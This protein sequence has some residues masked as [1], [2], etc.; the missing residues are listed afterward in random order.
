M[1]DKPEVNEE[2]ETLKGDI[3][4]LR[5]ENERLTKALI[6]NEFVI[7]EKSIEKK[8]KP[9]MIEVEGEM[10]N[11]ADIPAVILKKLEA[12]AEEL[13][14]AAA[15]EADIELTKKA[16]EALP[17]FAVDVAKTLVAKFEGDEEVMKA[18][19]AA[20]KVFAEAQEEVGKAAPKEMDA[21][22]QFNELVK[23]YKDEHKVDEALATNDS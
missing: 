21:E 20:D 18:L 7:S 5:A 8:A 3:E 4:R 6:D 14:K 12:D 22:G 13:A 19:G 10:V 1:A 9:E 2:L 11:K 23:A 17:N 15:R 16:E